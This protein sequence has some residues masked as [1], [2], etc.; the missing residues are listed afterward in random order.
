MVE[1]IKDFSIVD[2][3]TVTV[4]GTQQDSNLLQIKIL[5]EIEIVG[6]DFTA[7][8]TSSLVSGGAPLINNVVTTL[9]IQTVDEDRN[10]LNNIVANSAT[11]WNPSPI[12]RTFFFNANAGDSFRY[13]RWRI[14]A[15]T[16]LYVSG[17]SRGT[18]VLNV[19]EILMSR[20]VFHYVAVRNYKQDLRWEN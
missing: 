1:K 11:G 6:F 4:A 10:L 9:S 19:N 8:G 2:S 5:D 13:C 3:K 7:N 20:I 12:A 16:S 15:G 14:P 17:K 18:A